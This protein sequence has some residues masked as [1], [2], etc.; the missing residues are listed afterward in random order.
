LASA[1]YGLLVLMAGTDVVRFAPSLV[2]PDA[3]IIEGMAKFEQAVAKVV[4]G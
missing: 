1:E 2:I 4:H 3:D